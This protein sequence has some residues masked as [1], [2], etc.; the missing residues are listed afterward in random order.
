MMAEAKLA[1]NLPDWMLEHTKRYLASGGTD[2]RVLLWRL[3][4]GAEVR[5][6]GDVPTTPQDALKSSPKIQSAYQTL[7]EL[8]ARYEAVRQRK[9]AEYP[10][11]DRSA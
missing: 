11:V 4:D 10:Y 1:P 3:P 2:S 6:L 5:K 9:Q 8:A 7:L